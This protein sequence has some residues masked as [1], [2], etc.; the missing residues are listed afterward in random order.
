VGLVSVR[1]A[2]QVPV[3]DRDSTSLDAVM[4]PV[5]DIPTAGPDDPLAQL[6]PALE[7]SPARRALVLVDGRVV[8]IVTS[9]DVSRVI[10]WLT[11]TTPPGAGLR[12]A[13][14]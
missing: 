5:D 4:V 14:P 13:R 9:S 8:G 6:V 10:A 1:Q 3:E 7:A 11:S 2:G 12:T